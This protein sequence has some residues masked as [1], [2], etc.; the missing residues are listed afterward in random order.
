M[1]A[2]SDAI[3]GAAQAGD[4][5]IRRTREQVFLAAF[6]AVPLLFL[7]V[8]LIGPLAMIV[9]KSLQDKRGGFVWFDN[10]LSYFS[11]PRALELITNSVWVSVVATLVSVSLAFGFAAALARTRIPGKAAFRAIAFA[12]MLAPSLLSALATVYLFGNQGL[13][14]G[15]MFG[16][17]IYGPIGIIICHVFY[18]FP[19][20]FLLL[21]TAFES[22]DGR[23]YEAAQSLRASRTRVFFTVTLPG[24]RYGLV[25]A[26]CIVFTMTITDFGIPKV[27][28]GQFRVF[29][30]EVYRQVVGWQNFQLGAVISTVLLVPAI[31]S[32]VVTRAMS[33]DFI[34]SGQTRV[35]FE[36]KPTRAQNVAGFAFCSIVAVAILGIYA[37]AAFG[38]LVKF[39]PYDLSLTLSNYDFNGKTDIGWKAVWTSVLI[40]FFTSLVGTVLALMSAYAVERPILPA[41]LRNLTQGIS[42]IPSAVPGLVLGLGYLAFFNNPSNPLNVLYGT[43]T[44]MVVCSIVHFY[45]VAQ[46]TF[47]TA[48]KKIDPNFES[49]SESLRVGRFALFKRV[50][51]PLLLPTIIDVLAYF[52]IS[53]MTTT[54]AVIMIYVPATVTATIGIVSLDDNGTIATAI[55]MGMVVVAI[56]LVARMLEVWMRSRLSRGTP[57]AP[58][59]MRSGSTRPAAAA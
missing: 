7:A 12:P 49:V 52:F 31:V 43:L 40:A 14:K 41:A 56:C 27:I 45:T 59:R 51:L 9:M 47:Q 24:V 25:S 11:T 44:I 32:F 50:T 19:L 20:A 23:L 42:L 58:R 33:R 39:W 22:A 18:T 28:G 1:A 8:T 38:S 48:L 13:F 5:S 15:L 2:A 6:V 30:T 10:Y 46:S 37:M 35:P 26:L 21:S 53:T 4:R 29:A 16:H 57:G 36:P 3:A 17:T 55:A 34:I 54:S